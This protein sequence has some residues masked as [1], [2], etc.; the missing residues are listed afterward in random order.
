MSR[1]T[2]E[3]ALEIRITPIEKSAGKTMPMDA[4]SGTNRLRIR[5]SMSTTVKTPVMAAAT[6]KSGEL[7]S[8]VTKKAMTMP[9]RMACEMASDTM[10]VRRRTR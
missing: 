6:S 3:A 7:R 2:S 4:S 10:A 8:W 1:W 5:V 9:G